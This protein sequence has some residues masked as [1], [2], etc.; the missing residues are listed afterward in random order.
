M[1][2]V[3]RIKKLDAM[4]TCKDFPDAF[5]WQI[6]HATESFSPICVV[7]DNYVDSWLKETMR[8][9][10]TGEVT[11]RYKVNDKTRLEHLSLKSFLSHIQTK[12]ELMAYLSKKVAAVCEKAGKVYVVVYH[13]RCESNTPV[14]EA[15]S[16]MILYATDVARSDPFRELVVCSPDTDVFLLSIF[17]HKDL[18]NHTTFRTGRENS[19]RDRHRCNI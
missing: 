16:L 14:D 13:N 15:N 5:V 17:F 12:N 6:M 3:N 19:E 8:K 7:F 11:V 2:V 18:C 10:R 4:R 1:A 9:K